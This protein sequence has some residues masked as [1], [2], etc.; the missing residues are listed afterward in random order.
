MTEQVFRM[1][2]E[3]VQTNAPSL[4]KLYFLLNIDLP[5]NTTQVEHS[6]A[7]CIINIF[8]NNLGKMN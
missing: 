3:G 5:S 2:S 4:E 7:N 1:I 8:K 6:L